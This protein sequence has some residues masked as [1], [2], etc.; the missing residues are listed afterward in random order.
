MIKSNEIN[1]RYQS[2]KNANSKMLQK[3]IIKDIRITNHRQT[4]FTVSTG[5]VGG[6]FKS[7]GCTVVAPS[8]L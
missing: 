3:A 1:K 6:F 5:M 8:A 7:S 2:Y 4:I